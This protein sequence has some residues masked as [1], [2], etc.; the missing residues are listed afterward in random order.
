MAAGTAIVASDIHGYKGVL[1]RGR[2]ACSCRP[3]K[4]KE[5][6]GALAKLLGDDELRESMARS[7]LERAEEFSWERVTAKVEDY[8]GFVIR[9][10][11]AQGRLPEGF[12]AEIPPSPRP[13]P[14]AA[15]GPSERARSSSR[16]PRSSRRSLRARISRLG[17][18]ISRLMR[19]APTRRGWSGEPDHPVNGPTGIH[20]AAPEFWPQLEARSGSIRSAVT[21]GTAA[22]VI[23]RGLDAVDC[24]RQAARSI[25]CG[26]GAKSGA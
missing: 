24:S 8:Y 2:R 11:A 13:A 17:A 3:G 9:R 5:L 23:G 16:S 20:A 26:L 1:Q 12:H 21:D 22:E 6:A 18:R 4:P 14:G 10:L 25:G 15:A 7:G 19:H